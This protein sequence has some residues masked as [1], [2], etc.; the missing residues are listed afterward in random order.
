M[1]CIIGDNNKF[2]IAIK[3]KPATYGPTQIIS[4]FSSPLNVTK[5]Y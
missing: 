3:P 2:C 4:A 5:P 1:L